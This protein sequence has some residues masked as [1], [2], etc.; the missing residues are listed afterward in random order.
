M[1]S[2]TGSRLICIRLITIVLVVL[3]TFSAAHAAST[4]TMVIRCAKSGQ[5]RSGKSAAAVGQGSPAVLM[6]LPAARLVKIVYR[7]ETGVTET[8]SFNLTKHADRT[9]L[10]SYAP[11]GSAAKPGKMSLAGAA[12]KT[13][14]A[15]LKGFVNHQ[16][17]S[18]ADKLM[19]GVLQKIIQ[20]EK[21]DPN[22]QKSISGTYKPHFITIVGQLLP[23]AKQAVTLIS[24]VPAPTG[25][26]A[27]VRRIYLASATM[28]HAAMADIAEG[29][30]LGDVKRF[31]RGEATFAR[32]IAFRTVASNLTGALTEQIVRRHKQAQAAATTADK[33]PTQPDYCSARRYTITSPFTI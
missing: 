24:Q 1:A 17:I 6:R 31:A 33:K 15:Q 21:S 13:S 7:P 23:N 11:S 22:K 18:Q 26:L 8:M 10:C 16:R 32:A 5:F 3:G 9:L 27:E 29:T 25:E 4:V 12:T 28:L 20:I 2:Q 19:V 14:V 30:R